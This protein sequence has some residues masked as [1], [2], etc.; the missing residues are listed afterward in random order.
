MCN[1]N[2]PRSAKSPLM[3]RVDRGTTLET[4][5]LNPLHGTR[6]TRVLW[7][8]RRESMWQDFYGSPRGG[9]FP[10][11]QNL[12]VVSHACHVLCT[13][14][15]R[16]S[17]LLCPWKTQAR[18]DRYDLQHGR[19]IIAPS[20]ESLTSLRPGPWSI[21]RFMEGPGPRTCGHDR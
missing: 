6:Q 7:R 11:P 16:L 2:T 15:S 18:P 5:L 14:R 19:S 3:S 17:S 1:S 12:P 13:C 21:P 4:K 20:V 9:C 8:R 10:S